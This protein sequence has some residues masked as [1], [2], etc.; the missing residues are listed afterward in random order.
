MMITRPTK[1]TFRSKKPLRF[2]KVEALSE[3]SVVDILGGTG[4]DLLKMDKDCEIFDNFFN[5]Y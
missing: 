1:K 5:G 3:S 2:L 4:I